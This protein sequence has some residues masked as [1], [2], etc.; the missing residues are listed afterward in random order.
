M[1]R[2]ILPTRGYRYFDPTRNMPANW[3]YSFLLWCVL[4]IL[5]TA[6]SIIQYRFV[7]T[8][9]PAGAAIILLLY[10]P[11]PAQFACLV[12]ITAYATGLG[13]YGFNKSLKWSGASPIYIRLPGIRLRPSAVTTT[14]VCVLIGLVLYHLQLYLVATL[15][16]PVTR[17][18]EAAAKYPEVVPY[19]ALTAVL[20][21]P[22]PEELV[23]R[24]ALF[25]QA[26]GLVRNLAAVFI[27][28]SLFVIVHLGQYSSRADQIHWG[29]ISTMAALGVTCGLC[30]ALLG[31]V[32]PAFVVHTAYNLFVAAA[33]F[34]TRTT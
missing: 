16:G 1:L 12:A 25:T 11:L 30:R 20:T 19:L 10:A 13:P 21:A 22:L 4:F 31:R 29:A 23:Y 7:E 17:A 28:S 24:G 2:T 26:H 27:S 3:A 9:P 5:G 14:A 6:L 34:A 32:W 33:Y 18:D 8:H 15:G